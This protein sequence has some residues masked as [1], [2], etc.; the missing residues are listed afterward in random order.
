ME[1]NAHI[2]VA[3]IVPRDD[4]FL[5]VSEEHGQ[6]LVFNQPAGHWELHETLV[7]AAQRETL[8]ETCWQTTVTDF[9]GFGFYTSPLNEVTYCRANFL[10][11]PQTLHTELE[12]DGDIVDVHW[13]SYAEILAQ[14]DKL[15]SPLVLQAIE[16][17]RAGVRYPLDIIYHHKS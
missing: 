14:R 2:T 12:R 13:L 5:M 8:E 4:H 10:A 17:Y 6:E 7:Q 15:R 11:L 16:S 9:L 1:I 3:C